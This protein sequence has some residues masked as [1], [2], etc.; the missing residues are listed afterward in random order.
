MQSIGP[1]QITDIYLL[2]M[3]VQRK[4]RFVTF[5]ARV[6]PSAIARA[7]DEQLCVI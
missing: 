7:R 4:G 3:A 1:T 6:S 5:D 2:A